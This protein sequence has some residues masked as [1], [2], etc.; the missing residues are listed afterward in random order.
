VR[1]DLIGE[2]GLRRTTERKLVGVV[3][4]DQVNEASAALFA[5]ATT[6]W[7]ERVRTEAGLRADAYHFEVDSDNPLNS[8]DRTATI[9]SPKLGLVLGPWEKTEIYFNAGLGFHSNDARGATIRVDP[10]DGAPIERVDPLVGSR[11]AEAG[12][13]S[14]FMPGLVSTLSWWYLDLDSELVFVGDAGGTEPSGAS[15][16]HGV[17]FANFYRPTPWLTLDADLS[18]THARYRNVGAADRIANSIGTVVTAG[19]SAGRSEGMFG[20]VRLRYFGEQP[21]VDDNALTQP[22][23]TTLNA[24]V[25]WRN[26]N[27]EFALSLLNALDRKNDDIAYY[28]TS[29]L[30]GE[31][32]AGIDDKHLHPAEPRTIRV[33][34][35]R[36][37]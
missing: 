22:A 14:S 3:R 31:P 19:I 33:S 37:F 36:R 13:R 5:N 7:S 8:G 25:G 17:E 10:V 21:L 11:G 12:V 9:V 29:R 6:R 26:R 15:R 2:L 35:S 1:D 30:Q 16:R 4:S 24:R 18:L 23:S 27:W 28:Y 32:L 20:S 34:A